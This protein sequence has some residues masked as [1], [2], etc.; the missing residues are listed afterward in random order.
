MDINMMLS[1]SKTSPRC[2][3]VEKQT[4][5]LCK[6]TLLIIS[7]AYIIYPWSWSCSQQDQ[8]FGLDLEARPMFSQAGIETKT[9]TSV[10]KSQ[11]KTKSFT[12]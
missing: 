7:C 4:H 10:A 12:K 6:F 11:V 8:D 5:A 9:E 3:L 2:S 1:S